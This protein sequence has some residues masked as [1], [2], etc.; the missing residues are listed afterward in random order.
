MGDVLVSFYSPCLHFTVY[1]MW[2][3]PVMSKRLGRPWQSVINSAAASYRRYA[4]MVST[5]ARTARRAYRS[6]TSAK[7]RRT[8]VNSNNVTFQHDYASIYNRR[9]APRKVRARARRAYKRFNHQLVNSLGQNTWAVSKAFA[10]G[11][12]TPTSLSNCQT[13]ASVGLYGAEDPATDTNVTWSDLWTIAAQD[14]ISVGRK[15]HFKSACLD[16]QIRNSTDSFT[17]GEDPSPT[18]ICVDLYTIYA[19][20]DGYY[21]PAL[22]W[23]AGMDQQIALHAGTKATPQSLNATPFD[24]PGF[25][26]SYLIGK[27]TRYRIS[28]GNSVYLQLRDSK[29]H[30]WSTDKLN[31]NTG[32][33]KAQTRFFKGYS[34]GYLMAIR[35]A[36]PVVGT[37]SVLVPY[38]FE[39]VY[40]KNYKYGI[41]EDNTDAQEY[42]E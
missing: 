16:L 26:S 28:P 36:D 29:D 24:A 25:C 35:S 32:T 4:P 9:R 7:R 31:W 10:S 30:Q 14:G 12:I 37:P 21:A 39:L 3:T 13:I 34:K 27:K 2:R 41:Q 5:V 42:E 40:T 23:L 38:S 8:G 22:D 33:S 6:Y 1:G 11:V 18:T 15:Y 17:G 19:R 20:K